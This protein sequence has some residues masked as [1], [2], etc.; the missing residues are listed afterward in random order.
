MRCVA[1]SFVVDTTVLGGVPC[2][3]FDEDFR[4]LGLTVIC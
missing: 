1:I 3:A 4:A 2:P